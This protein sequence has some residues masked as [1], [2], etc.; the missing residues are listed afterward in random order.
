M[1]I[2]TQLKLKLFNHFNKW[3]QNYI[4]DDSEMNNKNKQFIRIIRDKIAADWGSRCKE[5]CYGCGTCGAYH[6]LDIIELLYNTTTEVGPYN[7]HLHDNA[8]L[9]KVDW[10]KVNNDELFYLL[11]DIRLELESRVDKQEDTISNLEDTIDLIYEKN[12]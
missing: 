7:T 9:I 4:I 10:P 1:N 11:N 3:Y 8:S 5:Y 2:L 12:M 6:A